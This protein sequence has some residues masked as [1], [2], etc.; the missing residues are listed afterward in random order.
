LNEAADLI[1]TIAASSADRSGLRTSVKG[2]ERGAPDTQCRIACDKFV[3]LEHNLLSQHDI[4]D[5][6]TLSQAGNKGR[7][8]DARARLADQHSSAW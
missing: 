1:E 5:R 4:A 2:Y 7:Q 8:L 3:V 6:D